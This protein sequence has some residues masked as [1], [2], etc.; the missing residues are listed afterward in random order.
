MKKVLALLILILISSGCELFP[1]KWP[2][3]SYDQLYNNEGIRVDCSFI[4]SITQETTTSQKY[5]GNLLTSYQ[6][7]YPNYADFEKAVAK[8]DIAIDNIRIKELQHITRNYNLDAICVIMTQNNENIKSLKQTESGLYYQLESNIKRALVSEFGSLSAFIER[9]CSNGT[10]TDKLLEQI[11]Q[12]SLQP[13]IEELERRKQAQ[14]EQEKRIAKQLDYLASLNDLL[15]YNQFDSGDIIIHNKTSRDIYV[16][17]AFYFY[18]N[19]WD[20]WVVTGFKLMANQRNQ[21]EIPLS[22]NGYLNR[23]IYYC[24]KDIG[25]S[26]WSWGDSDHDHAFLTIETEE[27]YNLPY[28]DKSSMYARTNLITKWNNNFKLKDIGANNTNYTLNLTD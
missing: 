21:I 10:E 5:I 22:S 1:K 7:A 2:Q 9:I 20:G 27:A 19:N 17:L 6:N 11:A 23:Y 15:T 16:N 14:I 12:K 3:N 24:A 28:A 8:N 13:I 4:A 26:Y 18:G 25:S